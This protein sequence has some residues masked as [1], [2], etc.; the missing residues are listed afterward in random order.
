M[1][2][3]NGILTRSGTGKGAGKILFEVG[4]M[5]TGRPSNAACLLRNR[6]PKRAWK[7]CKIKDA[8][9]VLSVLRAC[10]CERARTTTCDLAIGSGPAKL[11]TRGTVQPVK[12]PKCSTKANMLGDRAEEAACALIAH[13]PFD[14]CIESSAITQ[15]PMAQRPF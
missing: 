6:R 11:M 5:Q 13:A 4:M 15:T 14:P 12:D 9:N 2:S 3:Q 8:D 1:S 7:L 10:V